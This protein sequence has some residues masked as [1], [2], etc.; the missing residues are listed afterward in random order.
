MFSSPCICLLPW[1]FMNRFSFKLCKKIKTQRYFIVFTGTILS[2]ILK[3]FAQGFV[4]V[5]QQF[6]D[7]D[8]STKVKGTPDL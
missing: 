3:F 7:A 8:T 5:N 1:L 6:F 2:K 4:Y